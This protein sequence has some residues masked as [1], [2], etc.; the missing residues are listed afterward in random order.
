MRPGRRGRGPVPVRWRSVS[1]SRGVERAGAL[2][3]GRF[4]HGSILNPLRRHQQTTSPT[5]ARCSGRARWTSP[6][7]G[8]RTSRS[9]WPSRPGAHRLFSTADATELVADMLVARREFLD[10]PSRAGG[11]AGAGLVRRRQAGGERSP[12]RRA[13]R[14]HRRFALPRRARLREDAEAF[15]WAKWTDARRQRP[16]VRPGRPAAG[17]RPRLQPGRRDLDRTTRRP[18]SR[19]A[20]R[21]CRCA[22]IGTSPASGRPRA[23]RRATGRDVRAGDRRDGHAAV[24]QAGHASRSTR[25]ERAHGR[26]D[27]ILNKQR[28]PQVEMAGGMYIRVEGNTDNLGD[29]LEPGA[30]RAAGAGHRRL[31]GR[32]AASTA[33]LVARGNGAS[34]P[35][36]SNKTPEGRA[37]TAAPTS[38][39]SPRG[40]YPEEVLGPCSPSPRAAGRG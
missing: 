25:Q 3:F 40:R 9:R 29:E 38:C 22:T 6:A 39:S 17:L 34:K 19:I 7:C 36:A 8:S 24:H 2:R 27:G 16:H 37:L 11:E 5:R 20:S 23:R 10:R 1:R 30:E 26:D 13:P 15:D 35:M 18:R 33:R 4:D 28:R 21:R 31:P 14:R 12:R 32:A